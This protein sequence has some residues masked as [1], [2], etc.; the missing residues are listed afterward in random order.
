MTLIYMW[1]HSVFPDAMR[2]TM[3]SLVAVVSGIAG[4]VVDLGFGFLWS[5]VGVAP[6]T[7]AF[8]VVLIAVTL[9]VVILLPGANPPREAPAAANA[10][11]VPESEVAG[12]LL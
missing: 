8:G 2:N 4:A 5:A 7:A 1:A 10:A 9:A 3:I 6:A 12:D 11:P